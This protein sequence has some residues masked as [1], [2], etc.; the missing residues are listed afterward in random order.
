MPSWPG[1]RVMKL[2]SKEKK[3]REAEMGRIRQPLTSISACDVWW[4]KVLTW[5]QPASTIS[6][7]LISKPFSKMQPQNTYCLV[8]AALQQ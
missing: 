6:V 1:R 4:N 7:A 3:H 5:V 2:L 8:A